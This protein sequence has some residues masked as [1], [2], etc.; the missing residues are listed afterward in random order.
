MAD[1]Q[2][3]LRRIDN[4]LNVA[5]RQASDIEQIGPFTLYFRRNS[6][7]PELSY[8]RPTAP[9]SGDLDELIAGVRAAFARRESLCRWEF[10]SDLFPELPATL[11]QN[12]FPEPLPR[13]LMV[14]TRET[15][16]PESG[17]IAEVRPVRIEETRAVSRVLDEAFRGADFDPE[18]AESEGAD[19]LRSALEKGAGVYAAFVNGQPVAGG[20]HSPVATTTEVAGIGTL[21]AFRRRGIAGALTSALVEDAFERGCEWVFLSAADETVQRIY[22]RIGFEKIG[23]AMDTADAP[24]QRQQ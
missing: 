24:C 5:P 12:G 22:A 19:L 15:F 16:Q 4:Y 3:L 8:A 10:L 1:R 9:L 21:P 20:L 11:V 6:P 13:P 17:R 23:T 2:A 7:I 14:V 18:S